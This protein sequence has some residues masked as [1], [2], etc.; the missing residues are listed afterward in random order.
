MSRRKGCEKTGGRTKGT[1]NKVTANVKQWLSCLLGDNR[2][3]FEKALRCLNAS[4]FTKTYIA[5]LS[6]TTPKLQAMTP[7]AM[8]EAEYRELEKLLNNAPDEVIDEI[9]ERINRLKDGQKRQDCRNN[10]AY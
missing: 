6:F 1:P 2:E 4:E 7:E 8:F 9:V 3:K 5:L 10:E